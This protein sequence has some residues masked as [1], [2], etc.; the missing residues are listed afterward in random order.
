[1]SIAFYIPV[2]VWV[3]QAAALAVAGAVECSST[4]PALAAAGMNMARDTALGAGAGEVLWM[5]LLTLAMTGSSYW[6]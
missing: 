6:T 4:E 2:Q 1:M 3:E 5:S